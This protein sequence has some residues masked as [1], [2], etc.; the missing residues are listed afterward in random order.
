MSP[1]A[2][3]AV[4]YTTTL[5]I[6]I[7]AVAATQAKLGRPCT[8]AEV[9]SALAR[10]RWASPRQA[11][12]ALRRLSK[13]GPLEDGRRLVRHHGG[14]SGARWSV[15]R[16]ATDPQPRRIEALCTALRAPGDAT[17]LDVVERVLLAELARAHE[18]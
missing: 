18:T 11:A 3:I 6:V 7:A 14:A 5:P 13:L 10:D 12:H 15:Q 17:A 16:V 8:A 4:G 9:W 1:L 2:D